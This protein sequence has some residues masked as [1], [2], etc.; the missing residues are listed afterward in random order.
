MDVLA[1]SWIPRDATARPRDVTALRGGGGGRRLLVALHQRL[2]DEL[3]GDLVDAL[4]VGRVAV[5]ERR[6]HRRQERSLDFPEVVDLEAGD[7]AV[8]G[9]DLVDEVEEGVEVVQRLDALVQR[10]HD[11]VRVLR[12]LGTRRLRLPRAALAELL[13]HVQQLPV[14]LEQFDEHADAGVLHGAR[15][16]LPAGQHGVLLPRREGQARVAG[17]RGRRLHGRR[18][19]RRQLAQLTTHCAL[20]ALHRTCH[21]RAALSPPH[22]RR[23]RGRRARALHM[24]LTHTLTHTDTPT[25]TLTPLAIAQPPSLS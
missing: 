23:A 12:Q 8:A 15:D 19:R 3:D 4:H 5:A 14:L 16:A 7:A 13:E 9:A 22:Y 2:Q 21:S 1:G 18:R 24:S 17:G 10:A 11:A 20:S 25:H 6:L